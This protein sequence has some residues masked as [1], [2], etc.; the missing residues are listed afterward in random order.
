MAS[1]RATFILFAASLLSVAS[2]AS[3]QSAGSA[4]VSP[5][6]AYL[7]PL[8]TRAPTQ[9]LYDLILY[10]NSSFGIEKFEN[11][12]IDRDGTSDTVELSCPGSKIQPSDPCVLEVKPTAGSPYTVE[13]MPL[14]L[15]R[16]NGGI[17]AIAGDF[18]EWPNGRH[19]RVLRLGATGARLTCNFMRSSK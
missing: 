8:L 16:Y 3:A 5:P 19:I 9:K 17:Y 7:R 2:G 18:S 13:A 11:V 15:M 10:G 1:V 12:D 6:C 4:P 14:Y